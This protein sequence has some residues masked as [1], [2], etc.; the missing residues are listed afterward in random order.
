[1]YQELI[2]YAKLCFTNLVKVH[3]FQYRTDL[4]DSSSFIMEF[5]SKIFNIKIEKYRNEFYTTLCKI[6]YPNDEIN[7]YN[8]LDY[9]FKTDNNDRVFSN[10][11]DEFTDFESYKLQIKYISDLIYDNFNAINNFFNNED[12]MF[13]YEDLRKFIIMKYP[14]IFG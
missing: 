10:Y 14:D 12:Y 6:N 3:E 8:L 1:M 2:S 13:K 7:L 11:F 4:I 9:I 5:D